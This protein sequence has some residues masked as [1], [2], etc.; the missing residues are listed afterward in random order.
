MRNKPHSRLWLYFTGVIFATIFTVFILIT[1][2]W[3]ALYELNLIQIDPRARHIPIV[4]FCLGSILLGTIIA[5]FVGKRII[6]PIQHLSDAFGELSKGNFNVKIS[7]DEK[8]AEIREMAERFNTMTYDL[9]HMETLRNDFVANVSHEFKTPI[10]AIEGYAMLLQNTKLSRE[11]HD[12][13]VEIILDNSRRLSNLTSQILTLSKLENQEMILDNREFRLD[14][15]IRKSVLL[16]ERKWAPKN[17]EFD[18]DLQKQ[19]YYGSESLLSQVWTNLLDNAIKHSSVNGW[20]HVTIQTTD[21]QI[22]VSITDYGDG[23]TEEVKKHIFEKFYQGDHSRKAEGNGLGLA[24]VKRI[25]E[26]CHG[27][28]LLQSSP[29][30]GATF[31]VCLPLS[32]TLSCPASAILPAEL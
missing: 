12:H 28:I 25:V 24:L 31:S 9:S 21:T 20:I 1:I 29:G 7:S 8:I 2:F 11:K 27:T 5:L 10:A 30:K 15:Q 26:I 6:R 23:M 3:F 17:I 18:M 22:I 16:L 32:F 13:Y 19:M 4:V 14:E